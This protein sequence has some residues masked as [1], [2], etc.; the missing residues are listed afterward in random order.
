MNQLK[1]LRERAKISQPQLAE[2]LGVSVST[3]SRV[4]SRKRGAS[5]NLARRWGDVL[6]IPDSKRYDIF[7]NL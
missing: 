7:F 6:R 3:V 5:K 4:E 2:L 1:E